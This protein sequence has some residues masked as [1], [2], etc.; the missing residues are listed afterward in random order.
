MKYQIWKFLLHLVYG[1][2]QW[3]SSWYTQKEK[4]KRIIEHIFGKGK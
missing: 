1:I 2:E 4:D 3:L